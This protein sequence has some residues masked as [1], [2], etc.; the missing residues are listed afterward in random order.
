MAPRWFFAAAALA[1]VHT[2]APAAASDSATPAQDLDCAIWASMVAGST[3]D[4][5]ALVGIASIMGYF[6]GRYETAVGDDIDEAMM[7]RTPQVAAGD[8][9][10]LQTTCQARML[11][12][13]QRLVALGDRMQALGRELEAQ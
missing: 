10:G 3:T 13:G 12:F 4:K 5:D 6:I 8:L 7:A 11:R 1:S 2:A 9:T